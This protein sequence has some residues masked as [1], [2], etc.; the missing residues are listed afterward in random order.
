MKEGYDISENVDRLMARFNSSQE[1]N[2]ETTLSTAVPHVMSRS[3]RCGL[4][5][6]DYDQA[7]ERMYIMFAKLIAEVCME[8]AEE[9]HDNQSW[10]MAGAFICISKVYEYKTIP[11]QINYNIDDSV[12]DHTSCGESDWI[13]VELQEEASAFLMGE[14]GTKEALHAAT[15]IASDMALQCPNDPEFCRMMNVLRI[16]LGDDL[17]GLGSGSNKFDENSRAVGLRTNNKADESAAVII[18]DR[19]IALVLWDDFTHE[20]LASRLKPPKVLTI[21]GKSHGTSGAN[22]STFRLSEIMELLHDRF[23]NLR[24][25]ET[26]QQIMIF[27]HTHSAILTSVKAQYQQDTPFLFGGASTQCYPETKLWIAQRCVRA[28]QYLLRMDGEFSLYIIDKNERPIEKGFVSVMEIEYILKSERWSFAE[29]DITD[30]QAQDLR[31]ACL[32]IVSVFF[33]QTETICFME[34]RDSQENCNGISWDNPY[35]NMYFS[36]VEIFTSLT[37]S[38]FKGA[39]QSMG[40]IITDIQHVQRASVYRHFIDYR[41]KLTENDFVRSG[42]VH[43]VF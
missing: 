26:H 21:T 40:Q 18:T 4:Y 11:A 9:L 35:L 6:K 41:S 23:L 29:I 12:L 30:R 17:V 25:V 27:L 24:C 5:T 7:S 38:G 28:L 1:D 10:D 20:V 39:N 31:R 15:C 16:I 3:G 42:S 2:N 14:E 34:G 33:K 43:L 36:P 8:E 22:L 13:P 37:K 32:N 19:A